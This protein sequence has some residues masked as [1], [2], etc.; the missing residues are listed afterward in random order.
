M[1]GLTN[2]E[3]KLSRE[4]YGS[5][6]ITR[7]KNKKIIN[8]FVD[9]LG[10]PIIRILLIALAV[11]IVF[12]LKDF[13]WYETI[14]IVVSILLAS[15]VSTISEYGSEKA[16][17]KLEKEAEETSAK[18]LREKRVTEI[19]L[20]DIVKGDIIILEVGDKV[21]ADGNIIEGKISLDE[22]LINGEA[23]E[24]SKSFGDKLYRGTIVTEGKALMHVDEVGNNT[25]YGQIAKELQIESEESPLKLRLRT[26]AETISKIGYIGAALVAFS[27]LFNVIIIHNS[28]NYANIINTITNFRV[29]S[30]HILHALTLCVTVIIVS[31][32]EGL[33]MMITLVLSSNMK[34]LLKSN[35]LVRKLTG[36]ETTGSLNI[37]FTDKTG[38]LTK[39]KLEVIGIM[40]A[41]GEIES[42]PDVI[43][44]KYL[45]EN[46]IL[47]NESTYSNETHSAIGSNATDRAL[48]EFIR[49]NSTETILNKESFT[50]EKKYSSVTTKDKT[51]IKGAYE[52]LLKNTNKYINKFGYER[53]ILNKDKLIEKLNALSNKGI[54]IVMLGIKKNTEIILQGFALIRDEP[55]ENV[56]EALELV[57]KAGI[58]T[59]MITGD[60]K[61][62]AASIARELN[63][64][65]EGEY[66]ITSDELKSLTD[67][68][69]KQILPK[70]RVVARSLPSD[71]SRLV[72]ISQSMGYVTG[73][74]GDGINDAPALKKA[75]VGFSMGSGTEVAKEAS[76]IIILDNNFLSIT[77]A[78]LFGRTI[79]KS[80]RKFI[81]FQLT[82]N[83]CAL[84][85]SIIGP[86]INIESPITV[87]QMLW[88]NMVMDTLAGLAFSY[89]PPLM[90]YMEEK[91]KERNE[92]I[93]NKYMINEIIVTGLYS[94]LLLILFLKVPFFKHMFRPDITNKYFMT[95][96][97]TLFILITIF[98]SF[99]ARTSRINILADIKKNPVFLGIIIFIASI[100][101]IIIYFGGNVFRTY[102]LEVNEFISLIFIAL[103]VIPIDW[104]R[105]YILKI[106]GI[107]K[108]V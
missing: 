100:Q 72:K 51:Y 20:N 3:V 106:K 73:M 50:S 40:N 83:I 77:K 61:V 38:T 32:P 12:L 53:M 89:E 27:Y 66:V 78:I 105:K 71:K 22:S 31:V 99:N 60:S 86:F 2:E 10:D 104:L 33:P 102:G 30:S 17:E 74:T 46:L 69:V 103:T 41:N 52:K 92:K 57:S 108:G 37:L 91:P 19:K 68:E 43:Q 81:I 15:I 62:T 80:I 82:V 63:M 84:A 70:L 48:K 96:F 44:N 35:V 26:L 25:T 101:V 67:D 6:E 14:G 107:K 4:K 64:L 93:L 11:K 58:H 9:N 76:D 55:R 90:E 88:I 36:I 49:E 1:N 65:K 98:N 29:I 79:F 8:I 56:K 28:F 47:N 39:G 54:R 75:D 16:F 18:A 97:F 7:K 5:N 13:D 42:Y 94:S 95:G 24:K 59:I 21:P 85:I 34:K 23:K 45:K 87:V